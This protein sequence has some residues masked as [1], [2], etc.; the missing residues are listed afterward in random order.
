MTSMTATATGTGAARIRFGPL[1]GRMRE[2]GDARERPLLFLHGLTFDRRMWDPVLDALP[3]SRTALALDLPGHGGSP[4]L[5]E[6]G[7][8]AVVRAVQEAVRDAG[9]EEPVVVGHSIGG[10]LATLY[11]AEH[12]AAGVVSVEAPI[13]L[14]PFAA[15]LRSL[16]PQLAGDGFERA[17]SAFREGFMT[18]RVPARWRPLLRAGDRASQ[19]VVLGY[20]AD[21]LERPLEEVVRWRDAGLERLRDLGTPY[22]V[23]HANAQEDGELAWLAERLPQA[24]SLVWPVGHHFPHLDDPAAFAALVEGFAAGGTR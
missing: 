5:A 3:A 2:G 11:A 4:R 8:Q 19:E 15:L 20:Q 17:W 12:P 18:E 22:L 1:A 21:L 10:P 16:A 9:L 14:E 6:R 23:L 13:R 24:R 7:L